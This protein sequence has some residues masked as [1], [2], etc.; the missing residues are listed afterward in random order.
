MTKDWARHISAVGIFLAGCQGVIGSEVESESGDASLVGA[1]TLALTQVPSDVQCLR[2]SIQGDRTVVR[3]VA[4]VGGSS[5]LLDLGRLPL[6]DVV[7]SAN[8]YDA[9]CDSLSATVLSYI[10][11]PTSV[12]LATGRSVPVELNFR[13]NDPIEVDANFLGNVRSLAMGGQASGLL[14]DD[15]TVW[16]RGYYAY[17]GSFNDVRDIAIGTGHGCVVREDNTVW[18]WGWNTYGQIGVDPAE[19]TFLSDMTQVDLS[20]V[21]GGATIVKVYARAQST[22]ARSRT[23]GLYCWGRNSNGQL[24]DG[25]TSDS[26]TPVQASN[27]GGG[28]AILTRFALSE[29]FA[30]GIDTNSGVCC[31]GADRNGTLGGMGDQIGYPTWNNCIHA[32]ARE[33]AVGVSHVC[34]VTGDDTV[35]CWGSNADGQLGLGEGSATSSAT[36][37]PVPGLHDVASLSAG[38]NH[39]CAL[40]HDGEVLCW[41]NNG[42]GQT[43]AGAAVAS[44][45][46]YPVLSAATRIDTGNNFTCAELEDQSIQCWGSNTFRQ[47]HERDFATEWNPTPLE[48]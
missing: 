25:T 33:I 23:G 31:S 18:C 15:G 34:V 41:G 24:G 12:T 17:S 8:A 16:S 10:A 14:M 6:G 2:V 35:A 20:A 38:N 11:D 13:R 1:A 37:N 46:P 3:K 9:A 27:T 21:A 19:S 48:R 39:T 26:F 7:F 22:C 42:F 40:R 4:V 32:R 5:M 28:A 45:S 29:D 44:W 36:P 47:I 30:C 43:G